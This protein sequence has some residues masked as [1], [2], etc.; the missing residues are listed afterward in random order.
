MVYAILFAG[1]IIIVG[2]IISLTTTR[3]ENINFLDK[4]STDMMKGMAI[5]C[6][7]L[8]HYMGTFGQGITVFTPLG[9]IGVAIFLILSAYG[10]NESWNQGGVRL[11]EKT[12]YS[13]GYSLCNSTMFSILDIS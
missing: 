1:L 2:A 7:V 4:D 6:V 8:C 3:R 9:G 10:L 12:Y 13:S 11:V 5:L